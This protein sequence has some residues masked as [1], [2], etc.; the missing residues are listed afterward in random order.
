ML[1]GAVPDAVT[2]G[3]KGASPT[4]NWPRLASYCFFT[5][6]GSTPGEGQVAPIGA[7]RWLVVIDLGTIDGGS[8]LPGWLPEDFAQ[9]RLG[10]AHDRSAGAAARGPLSGSPA[11]RA[12]Q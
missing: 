5:S 6:A 12:I 1:R 4:P 7:H 11:F 2:Y 10:D 8:E 3:A 9:G